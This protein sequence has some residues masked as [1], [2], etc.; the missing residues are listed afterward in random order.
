MVPAVSS[1]SAMATYTAKPY[2]IMEFDSLLATAL[3]NKY[4]DSSYHPAPRDFFEGR[5]FDHRLE[6]PV[7]HGKRRPPRVLPGAELHGAPLVAELNSPNA[8]IHSA[9]S[10][11]F[12]RFEYPA[13][14]HRHHSAPDILPHFHDSRLQYY[15]P[16]STNDSGTTSSTLQSD[17]PMPLGDGVVVSC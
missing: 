10:C 4:M 12:T 3:S 11:S 5:S 8:L 14:Q 16:Y 15:D 2:A 7:D 1:V 13:P 6:R 17:G 9:S